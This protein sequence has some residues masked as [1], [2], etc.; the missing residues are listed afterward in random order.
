MSCLF[1]ISTYYIVKPSLYCIKKMLF[2]KNNTIRSLLY[3]K[4]LEYQLIWIKQ[5]IV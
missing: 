4:F 5:N 2:N 1:K 3:T